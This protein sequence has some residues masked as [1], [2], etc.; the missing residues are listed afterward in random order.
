MLWIRFIPSTMDEIKF[1]K[2]GILFYSFLLF[3]STRNWLEID[4]WSSQ[5]EYE[6]IFIEQIAPVV[7]DT[8]AQNHMLHFF[9]HQTPHF[10]EIVAKY[11]IIHYPI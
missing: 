11:R 10:A 2:Y 3:P 6:P 7:G 9:L 8:F 1:R 5:A 4:S